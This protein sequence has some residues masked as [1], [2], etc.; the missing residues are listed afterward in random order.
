MEGLIMAEAGSFYQPGYY[1]ENGN[2]VPA[3]LR[4]QDVIATT[5]EST[6]AHIT[7]TA[8]HLTTEQTSKISGAVQ[9]SVLLDSN[10]LVRTSM[11]PA[12]ALTAADQ[13]VATIAELLALS[14][15]NAP[16]G[17]NIFVGDATGDAT[18]KSGWALYRRVALEGGVLTDWTKV[19]EGEGLDVAM[20]DQ[21]ARD[22]AEA[23]MAEAQKLD[24]V[25][26][27]STDEMVAMNL[28]PGAL[29]FMKVTN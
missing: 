4:A 6:E 28:R 25:V 21:T 18:V 7:N 10:G 11:L 12:Q 22:S 17:Q 24:A 13:N 3:P 5:G 27:Q 16:V 9:S 8:I 14:A 19:S 2:F 1:D 15:A 20:V 29:V 26:C 23:A